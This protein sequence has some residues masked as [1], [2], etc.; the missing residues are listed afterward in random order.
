MLALRDSSFTNVVFAE[1]QAKKY[2]DY[3]LGKSDRKA[4]DL[5][6]IGHSISLS[7][8]LARLFPGLTV[9]KIDSVVAVSRAAVQ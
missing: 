8:T 7:V 6:S 3:A 5:K 4:I 2:G 9:C 1:N